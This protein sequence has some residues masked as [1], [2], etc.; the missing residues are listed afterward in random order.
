[1]SHVTG[2][3]LDTWEGDTL[4]VGLFSDPEHPGRAQLAQRFGDDLE[5]HLQLRRFQAKA[6]ESV[7]IE[8]LGQSPS[9]L[10][11]VGLGAAAD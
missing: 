2:N 8:R 10:A 11:I 1:M 5:Q 4:A 7:C 3:G 9:T 6:G